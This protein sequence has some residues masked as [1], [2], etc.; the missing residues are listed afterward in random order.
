[1]KNKVK[2]IL[3]NAL[4]KLVADGVIRAD[5]IA[6]VNIERARDPKHGDYACNIAMILA[7]AAAMKPR[8]LAQKILDAVPNSDVFAS[9]EIAGPGF[10]NIRLTEAAKRAVINDIFSQAGN[11]GRSDLGQGR[12]VQIE[13]VSANPTG[14][15]HVG[16]GRGA[17]YGSVLASLLKVAGYTV[18]CEYYVNDAGRQ[19]D[20]LATSVWLRYL[21]LCGENVVFP[22]NGYQGDYVFD[23]AADMHRAVAEQ[24]LKPWSEIVAGVV[25]DEDDNGNGD[26]ETHIDGLIAKAKTL[27]GKTLYR[28]FFDAGLTTIL[29]DIR[30]DLTEF[31][32]EFDEWFSERSLHDDGEVGKALQELQDAGRLYEKDGN[33]WLKSTDYGDDKDRVV[34]R[35]DG[36]HTYYSSD[37]AYHRH[38]LNRG[39]DQL[40]D[41]WGA[42][43]HG[44]VARVKAAMTALG[45]A[46]EKLQVLLVQFAVL[47]RG[48]EKVQ[49]STR[50]GQYVT[51][52]QLREEVGRDAAR[53]FYVLRKCEQHMDFDLQLATSK[54]NDNPVYYI[55]YAHARICSVMRQLQ[56][57]GYSYNESVGLKSLSMLSESHEIDLINCL[58]RYPEIIEIAANAY[59]PHHIA[60]YLREVA[61]DFHTYYNAHQFIV[62]D[63]PLRNARLALVLACRQVIRNGLDLLGVGA[64]ESM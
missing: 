36:S 34:Q 22:R 31:G 42:D 8:D 55:Q 52:R 41:I 28:R 51:L 18:S 12:K 11:F 14:P 33:L 9:C 63:E 38:K 61:N 44:Y 48:T 58:G 39:F 64:P 49:M 53:F 43:H 27:L 2:A 46:A 25:A 10:I 40:I 7:K 21:E 29:D 20:I 62:D 4:D 54:S 50:S 15:L 1:M 56:E 60:H 32:V 59:E 19:M 13:Y 23:I 26:K 37:I 3:V 35:A 24:G 47:Y 5:S 57:K 16:H 30:R 17:A 6:P 45:M